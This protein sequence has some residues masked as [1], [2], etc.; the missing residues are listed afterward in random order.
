MVANVAQA[1]LQT[2]AILTPAIVHIRRVAQTQ[3]VCPSYDLRIK[4][5]NGFANRPF[6]CAPITHKPIVAALLSVA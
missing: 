4:L 3:N 1:R 5:T 2:Y 6:A